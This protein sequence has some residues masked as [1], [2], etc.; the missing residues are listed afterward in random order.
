MGVVFG[1]AGRHE[2]AAMYMGQAVAARPEDAHDRISL[3]Q[4]LIYCGRLEEARVQCDELKRRHPSNANTWMLEGVVAGRTG[5]EDAALTALRKSAQLQPENA[6]AQYNLA[7]VL[8]RRGEKQESIEALQNCLAVAPEH[9]DALNNLAGVL[10]ADG[11]FVDALRLIQRHLTAAP[12]SAQGYANLSVAMQAGGDIEQAIVSL[13]N[14]LAIDPELHEV[15]LRLVNLLVSTGEFDEATREL[16]R[17][18]ADNQADHRYHAMRSRMLERQGKLDEAEAAIEQVDASEQDELPTLLSRAV[19]CDAKG[20]PEHAL[21]YLDR[22]AEIEPEAIEQIN[23]KFLRGKCL[24]ACKRYD[25]AFGDYVAGN[26]LRTEGTVQSYCEQQS[27]RGFENAK[28]TWTEAWRQLRPL[29]VESHDGPRP[30]FI[31]GMPR[32]GTS[33]TEQILG[34]HP[35][36]WPAGELRDL[37]EMVARTHQVSDAA[38]AK[39]NTAFGGGFA[40]FEVTADDR[41]SPAVPAAFDPQT[42]RSIRDGYLERIAAHVDA[43]ATVDRPRVTDKMPYNFWQVPLIRLAFPEAVIV[44]TRRHP[45][46]TCLSCFFQNFTAGNEFAFG[47]ESVGHYYDQYAQMMRCWREDLQIDL[48]E[49]DYERL[50]KDP[51]ATVRELLDRCGLPFDERCLQSHRNRRVVST[52]SYQQVRRPIYQKSR[53]RWRNYEK[54]LDPVRSRLTNWLDADGEI[55]R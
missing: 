12:R 2:Q 44:H 54:H 21:H 42:L 28:T 27:E 51:E 10:L 8:R 55:Q 29:E 30:I 23:L 11:Q 34:S 19:L 50:V 46:D 38:T 26:R 9:A 40:L 22:I 20:E 52:A 16:D 41:A 5:D 4:A 47:L 37:G 1:R 48:F 45:L 43:D 36:V 33:L 35:Q 39:S 3:T 15:R 6:Q 7:E 49:I 13:R 24:D 17:W 32:S 14:A 53:G 25:E 31:V 18:Q